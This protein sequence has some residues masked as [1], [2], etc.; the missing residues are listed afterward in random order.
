MNSSKET[1]I[2]LF[3]LCTIFAFVGLITTVI[4]APNAIDAIGYSLNHRMAPE[5]AI[6]LF[7]IALLFTLL[8]SAYALFIFLKARKK[9][10]AI[11]DDD[12]DRPKMFG[13]YDNDRNYLE[14]RINELSEQLVS[15]QKRWE[16]AYHLVVSS[17]AKSTSNSGELSSN[18]FLSKYNISPDKIEIDEKLVF[19]LTPFSDN[20][21]EDF[22]AIR[23]ACNE[24]GLFAVRGDEEAISGE[25]FS[26][27]IQSI[28]K[29]QLVVANI[30]GRNPNVFYELGIAHMM[31]KSTILVSRMGQEI[32][33]DIQ[34]RR[35]IFYD[36]VDELRKKLREAL[37]PF[38]NE[39]DNVVYNEWQFSN[40]TDIVKKV[41][42][43]ITIYIRDPAKEQQ[44]IDMLRPIFSAESNARLKI[45]DG[46]KNRFK[47]SFVGRLGK[48]R[49][50]ILGKLLLIL[51]Y[52]LYKNVAPLVK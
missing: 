21:I 13:K 26:H 22:Y 14:K 4:I 36:S 41:M 10:N 25:I 18:E 50:Y 51:D 32:P 23:T 3:I 43:I 52:K 19:V 12:F 49:M 8:S 30:N 37:K 15:T 20:Y 33:F 44:V 7:V 40:V 48:S 34:P 11:D 42:D 24:S 5:I 47:S 28:A 29:S 6:M 17:S 31:N 38:S 9:T 1:K 16:E 39:N 45:L 35:V 46:G 2:I 27:I